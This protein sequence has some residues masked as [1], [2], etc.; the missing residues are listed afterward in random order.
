MIYKIMQLA[1]SSNG[2]DYW[3]FVKVDKTSTTDYSSTSLDEVEV[4]LKELQKTI[5][6]DNLKVITEIGFTNDLIFENVENAENVV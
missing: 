4:K 1:N 2:I 6:L 5:L 3:T